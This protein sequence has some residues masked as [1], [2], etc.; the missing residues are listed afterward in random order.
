VERLTPVSLTWLADEVRDPSAGTIEPEVHLGRA[1]S[2]RLAGTPVVV[3]TL[4]DGSTIQV[5]AAGTPY[6]LVVENPGGDVGELAF[7]AFAESSTVVPPASAVP[8][9]AVV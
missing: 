8:L 1:G 2:G 5:A 4:S 9:A 3:V 7:S 6:P